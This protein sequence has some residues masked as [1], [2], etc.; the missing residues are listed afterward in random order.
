MISREEGLKS[1]LIVNLSQ[2]G[3]SPGSVLPPPRVIN[4]NFAQRTSVTCPRPP[5]VLQ[6]SCSRLSV[7]SNSQLLYG[8]APHN[9]PVL[10]S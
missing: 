8:V 6:G 3:L 5:S 2:M 9:A 4:M 7:P 10:A 1:V